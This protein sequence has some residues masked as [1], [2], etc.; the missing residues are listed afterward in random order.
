MY[1]DRETL[2][3]V[4]SSWTIRQYRNSG[5]SYHTIYNLLIN[6]ANTP[7]RNPEW[8]GDPSKPAPISPDE[9]FWA[10][11]IVQSRALVLNNTAKHDFLDP[12]YV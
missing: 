4:D 11:A 8:G 2:N 10:W 12:N 9:F 1:W 3:K 5:N 6:D 7:Y